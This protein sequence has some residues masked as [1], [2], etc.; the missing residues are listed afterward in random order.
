M[1]KRLREPIIWDMQP[2]APLRRSSHSDPRI[3]IAGGGVAALET[4]LALRALAED[5]VEIELLAP[6]PEF[7]YRP[8]VVAELFG[9]GEEHHFDLTRICEEQGAGLIQDGLA[10]VEPARHLLHTSTGEQVEYDALVVARGA[11]PR[12]AV[13]GAVTFAGRRD[14]PAVREVL[15]SA[16]DPHGGIDRIAFAAPGGLAWVLPLYELALMSRAELDAAGRGGVEL[17][18]ASPEDEPL[19]IFGELASE[20]IAELMEERRIELALQHY[21][22]AY[23]D[24]GLEVVPHERIQA[25]AVIAL[26]WLEGPYIEGLPCNGQGFIPADPHSAVAG[27]ED[28]YVAG[29][30]SNFPVKQGGLAS[31]QADA[32][33]ELIAARAGADLSPTPFRPMLRGVLLTGGTPTY[34]RAE[35]AGGSAVSSVS[36][37]PLWWPPAKV[38]GR[39][40]APYL[41]LR[42]GLR[43]GAPLV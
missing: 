26:P 40:L 28:V 41:A 19:G 25:D 22:T 37:S 42:P 30:A 11:R 24:G 31:Q 27:V 16:L 20:A 15:D 3:V 17:V 33:A 7:I 21:P 9:M 1:A 10:S 5:R 35:I 32:A 13:Q 18:I 14:V 2:L 34:L 29:D 8:M 36:N 43:E 39:Y 23:H 4:L 12:D 38:A 6:Q